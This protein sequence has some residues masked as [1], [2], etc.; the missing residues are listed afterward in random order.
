MDTPGTPEANCYMK[1]YTSNNTIMDHSLPT[2]EMFM[3]DHPGFQDMEIK[4]T[5]DDNKIPR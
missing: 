5:V 3:M 4:A 1:I 2:I